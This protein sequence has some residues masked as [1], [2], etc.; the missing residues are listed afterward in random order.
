MI[1][2][3]QK[4]YRIPYE[5]GRL[6]KV[7]AVGAATYAAMMTVASGSSWRTVFVRLGLLLLFPAGLLLLRFLRPQELADIRKLASTIRRQHEPVA[8]L[9]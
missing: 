2:L 7:V 3:A 6:A 1:V 4:A 8:S 5:V 9:P